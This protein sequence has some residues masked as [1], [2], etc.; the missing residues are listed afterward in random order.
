MD[1]HLNNIAIKRQDKTDPRVCWV[2][3]CCPCCCSNCCPSVDNSPSN[4]AR[5]SPPRPLRAAAGTRS[6]RN[7]RTGKTPLLGARGIK[8]KHGARQQK[9]S[10]YIFVMKNIGR[11]M[12]ILEL[13]CNCDNGR[14]KEILLWS[15]TIKFF[16]IQLTSLLV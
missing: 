2:E 15:G 3:R 13:P 6:V 4:R 9:C 12:I 7:A 8:L 10:R 1:F 5:L 11:C 14:N 16:I